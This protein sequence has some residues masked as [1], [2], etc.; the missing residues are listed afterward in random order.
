MKLFKNITSLLLAGAIGGSSLGIIPLHASAASITGEQSYTQPLTNEWSSNPS[1]FV[2]PQS[3]MMKWNLTVSSDM[4]GI[5]EKMNDLLQRT[6]FQSIT[7]EMTD[8]TFA[9]A[10]NR[11][12]VMV[13]TADSKFHHYFQGVKF[14]AKLNYNGTNYD[15]YVF[16]NGTFN[17]YNQEETK[18]WAWAYKGWIQSNNTGSNIQFYLPK[19]GA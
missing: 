17:T 19:L 15:V 1:G 18:P 12:N 2:Q 13:F 14:Y 9:F 4:L 6:T 3:M 5:S 8:Q 11:Y 7:R 10:K 16:E